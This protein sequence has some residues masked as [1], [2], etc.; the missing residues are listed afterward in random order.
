M[1][2][3]FKTKSNIITDI[4]LINYNIFIEGLAKINHK[5]LDYLLFSI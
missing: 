5:K 4:V 3:Y 1:F 2:I